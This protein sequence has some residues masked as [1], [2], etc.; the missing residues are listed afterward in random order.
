MCGDRPIFHINVLILSLQCKTDTFH[1]SLLFKVCVFLNLQLLLHVH[2]IIPCWRRYNFA[3]GLHG[4][5]DVLL[6][7]FDL[8]PALL[9]FLADLNGNLK[10]LEL[11]GLY[12]GLAVVLFVVALLRI[13]QRILP[14][15]FLCD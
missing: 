1:G 4:M 14:S 15:S 5:V 9:H 7:T 13:V 10:D 12:N 6:L 11:Q 8:V 2:L 3:A